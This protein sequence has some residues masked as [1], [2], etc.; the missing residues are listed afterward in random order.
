VAPYLPIDRAF[1]G[2]AHELSLY[3]GAVPLMLVLWVIAHRSDLG[4][5]KRFAQVT[6]GFAVAAMLMALGSQGHWTLL[7]RSLPWAS[8]FQ[9]SCRY[10][11]LFQFAVAVLAAMGF[12][13]VE[14]E[15]REKQKIERHLPLIEGKSRARLFWRQYELLGGAVLVS[16]AVA[17]AGLI[18]QFGHHVA[19]PARV[20]VGPLLMAAAALLVVAAAQGVRGALVGLVLFMA[21]DLGYYGLSCTLDDSVAR[22]ETLLSQIVAPPVDRDPS[23]GDAQ[24]VFAPPADGDDASSIGNQMTL[25]GWSRTDG[26]AALKPRKSLDYFQLAALRVAATRWVH[27]GPSTEGITGLSAYDEQWSQVPDPLSP[28]R[29]VTRVIASDHPAADLAHIDVRREALCEYALALPPGKPGTV[30]MTARR[31]GQMALK[32]CCSTP[33]LLVIAESYHPGW[34]CM[35]DG[36]PATVYRVNGDFLGCVV[37]PGNSEVRLEFRPDSLL[38]GRLVTL[39]GLGLIGLC[40]FTGAARRELAFVEKIGIRRTVP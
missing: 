17:V 4:G 32:V 16:L 38:R 29:L 27:R 14:R 13:L 7:P 21:A 24:R 25:A 10:T 30:A 26:C 8:W 2:N 22:P 5:M 23:E 19:S 33:Q 15:A 28:A 34:R 40:L 12:V 9:F 36:T 31:G 37:E 3:V 11:V 39:A 1:G 6:A 18:L 20:L 35:I